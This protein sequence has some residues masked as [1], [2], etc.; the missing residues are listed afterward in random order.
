ME[1]LQNLFSQVKDFLM[2]A[3]NMAV[4][5]EITWGTIMFIG[6]L[7]G[8]VAF[9]LAIIISLA[10]FPGQRKRMLKKLEQE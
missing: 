2:D 4:S 9:L 8:C 7:I 10:I 5:M 3:V 1:Q 6:G